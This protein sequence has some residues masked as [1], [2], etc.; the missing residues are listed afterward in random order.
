MALRRS[1][2][3]AVINIHVDGGEMVQRTALARIRESVKS[4]D[5]ITVDGRDIT[6][7]LS[8][9]N[10]ADAAAAIAQRLRERLSDLDV[11]VEV[12]E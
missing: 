10:A 2:G 3:S 12:A 6:I 9:R 1:S 11:E 7:E 8:D 4:N 5:P